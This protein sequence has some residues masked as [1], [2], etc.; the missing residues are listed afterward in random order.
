MAG[1]VSA[2]GVVISVLTGSG[3]QHRLQTSVTRLAVVLPAGPRAATRAW[4]AGLP[5]P[6]EP[7][8]GRGWRCRR[9]ERSL[10]SYRLVHCQSAKVFSQKS[11]KIV[12]Y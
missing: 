12:P 10:P 3:H 5:Q 11:V 2:D 6:A 7:G 8:P 9:R 4:P 1:P